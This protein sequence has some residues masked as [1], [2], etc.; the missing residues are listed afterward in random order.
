[1]Y[2]LYDNINQHDNLTFQSTI[3]QIFN[4]KTNILIEMDKRKIAEDFASLVKKK[5]PQIR[6]IILFGSVARKEDKKGSDI[7]LMLISDGDRREVK[8]SVMNDVV[9]TLL[10]KSVYVSAKVVSQNEYD[11]IRNTHFISEIEKSGVPIG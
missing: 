8:K 3:S 7:D 5:N 9:E 4:L 10:D 11:R 2:V 1:V 6:K